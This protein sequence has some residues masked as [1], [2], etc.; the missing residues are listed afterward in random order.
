MKIA[1][2]GDTHGN[3]QVMRKLVNCLPPID[4]ILHTGDYVGDANFLQSCTGIN[5]IKVAGNCDTLCKDVKVDEFLEINGKAL[6][7]THGHKYI[8]WNEVADLAYWGRHLEQDI[9]VYGHTHIPICEYNDN[10]LI[11]NPGSPS[12]PRGNSK[13][14]FAIL[15]L[16]EDLP[17]K[18]EFI[19]V[20]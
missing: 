9:I 10:I 18:V 2:T 12:R 17:V 8:K 20:K 15:T 4:L 11:I 16:A 3:Q 19:E 13:P 6:W 7:L 5:V 1:I 14:S